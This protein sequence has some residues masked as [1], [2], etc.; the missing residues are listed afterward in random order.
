[1]KKK[2]NTWLPIFPGFYGTLFESD[3][4]G[5]EIDEINRQRSEK[6]MDEITYDDCEWDYKEYN[7]NVCE[8]C[9]D[10]VEEQLNDIEID[11]SII[12]QSLYS[13]KYYNFSNDSINIEIE[14]DVDQIKQYINRDHQTFQEWMRHI[15]ERYTSCDGFIS[16]KSNDGK[17][18]FDSLLED[19]SE[20]AHT[21]GRALEFILINEGVD[22]SDMYN[23]S[24]DQGNAYVY[25]TNY[26]ELINGETINQ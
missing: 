21:I 19:E 10:F 24:C 22:S 18:W 15:K 12:F 1:M 17:Y 14:V 5:A 7:K 11:N 6:G 16:F 20:Q 23:Y 4:E 13:P 8:N 9:V 3:N 25:A 26:D 2:I